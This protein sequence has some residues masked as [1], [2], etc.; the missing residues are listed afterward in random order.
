MAPRL[1]I[2]DIARVQGVPLTESDRLAKLVP[3]RLLGEKGET[4]FEI[5]FKESA[6]LRDARDNGDDKV[7]DTLKYA[8]KLE[9]SV[10]QTG[11]H[12]CGVVIAPDDIENFAPMAT[13]KDRETGKDINVVQYEGKL[14]ESVGLIKMDFLGLKTLS[15]IKDALD[16]IYDL[17]GE[18]I[19]IDAIP[20]DDPKTFEL[21]SHGDRAFPV[22][23]A[24]HEEAP[25][26]PET[27]PLRGPDRDERT[28]PS[29]AYGVYSAVYRA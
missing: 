29:R 14:I 21:Y 11:V 17:R 9:G 25:A 26:Q 4:G 7:R 23:V 3:D 20:L 16:N 18:K 8:A 19:D 12:A 10:R 2:R 6:E 27:Q 22:R 5:A 15:I 28:L 13:S 24:R 1:A